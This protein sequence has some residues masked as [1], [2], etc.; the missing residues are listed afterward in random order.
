[1]SDRKLSDWLRTYMGYTLP[2]EAP[3]KF[4]F[5]TG[6]SVIAGA[7]R[8]RVWIDMGLFTW[9]P[10]FY[11]VFVA[12]PGIVSKS[13]T[14]A[15][16]MR[17][18]RNVK[19]VHFGPD[20][21]TWPALTQ[22]LASSRIDSPIGSD[23]LVPMSCITIAASEFGTFLNPQDR[24]MIDVLV[25]LWDSR[26]GLW[27]KR[28]KTAGADRVVN[29]WLNLA[30]CTTPGWIAGNFPEYLIGG[31]FTSRCVFV[32]ADKK[33]KLVAYPSKEMPDESKAMES[34]LA[35]DLQEIARLQG[36][37]VITPEAEEFG[38]AWYEEHYTNISKELDTV[39]F[40]G[41]LARKQTHIHKLAMVLSASEGSEMLIKKQH[42][43]AASEI[44]TSLESDM[45][46][47]FSTIGSQGGARNYLSIVDILRSRKQIRKRELYKM[48]A[49][50]MSF[51]EFEQAMEGAIFAGWV[52]IINSG[53]SIL[54]IYVPDKD[55]ENVKTGSE[56]KSPPG[57]S[58][59]D[60]GE[61]SG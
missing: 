45:P 49:G 59:N 47:V 44:V 14:L 21:V 37:Y 42:L 58:P 8:R 53:S 4:H 48:V 40:G 39:Q 15:V 26:I 20:A 32:F 13:T 25:D 5:W 18:L 12:P 3:D 7:L 28:T 1:L 24:E 38:E 34:A 17:F 52:E 22:A 54:Y 29:P 9:Y 46:Q 35:H 31:G 60:G 11:I 2:L 23:G 19:D 6:V 41:Y 33:R 56:T 36:Q 50:R 10:N 27:E 57:Q 55:Q 51:T 61:S 30:A 16:G 43:Y